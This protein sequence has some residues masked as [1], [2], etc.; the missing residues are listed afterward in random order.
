MKVTSSAFQNGILKRLLM[1]ALSMADDPSSVETG[2]PVTAFRY[3]VSLLTLC[4]GP[5]QRP[6]VAAATQLSTGSTPLL[7]NVVVVVDSGSLLT[8]STLR[9]VVGATMSCGELPLIGPC[10]AC[11]ANICDAGC[12]GKILT[13]LSGTGD[14]DDGYDVDGDDPSDLMIVSLMISRAVFA[15]G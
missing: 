13:R 15:R 6:S 2:Y 5:R 14:G 12:D 1:I 3:E 8:M 7:L 9:D 11:L 4:S 10:D